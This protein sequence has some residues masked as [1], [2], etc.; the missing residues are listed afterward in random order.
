MPFQQNYLSRQ[1]AM[2]RQDTS[3]SHS[4]PPPQSPS[5]PIDPSLALYP[6]YYS[7][8]PPQQ[9]HTQHLALPPHYSSPSSQGSESIGTPPLDHISFPSENNIKRP[10]STIANNNATGSRKKIR[11]D[12]EEGSQSPAAEREEGKAKPTRGAR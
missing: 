7:Y 11:K 9:M 6:P 5:I 12:E 3:A 4:M 1:D 10:A 8:Q 2:S